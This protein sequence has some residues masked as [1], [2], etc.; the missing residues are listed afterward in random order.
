MKPEA[1]ES[2]LGLIVAR[3]TL[4][5]PENEYLHLPRCISAEGV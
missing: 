1:P 5:T 2:T 3:R 4:C